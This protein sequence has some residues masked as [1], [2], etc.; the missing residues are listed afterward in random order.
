[1]KK[2]INFY[3]SEKKKAKWNSLFGAA[4]KIISLVL[5]SLLFSNISFSQTDL[6]KCY[7]SCTSGDFTITKA[8][9]SDANGNAITSAACST[10]G[11]TVTAYLSFIFSNNT[12]SDRNGIFISGTINGQYIFKCF[13]GVLPKKKTTTFTDVTHSVVWTCGTD[14]TLVGTF[15]SWGSR[16]AI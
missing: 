11:A 8:Y 16:Y 1:M 13:P 15:T 2:S 9:L 5:L 4:K 12:N 6:T 7:G 10:P 14:L 3:K